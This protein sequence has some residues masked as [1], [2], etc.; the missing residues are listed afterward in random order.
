MTSFV[1][2]WKMIK[3]TKIINSDS[4]FHQECDALDLESNQ[5]HHATVSLIIFLQQHTL[6]SSIPSI[7]HCLLFD[8]N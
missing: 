2:Y 5:L 4:T 8:P 3:I 7:P 6:P 1:D